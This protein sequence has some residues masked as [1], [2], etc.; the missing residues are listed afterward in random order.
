MYNTCHW[1]DKINH[2]ISHIYSQ[3]RG[4]GPYTPCRTTPRLHSGESEPAGAVKGRLCSNKRVSAPWLQ[5]ENMI[6]LFELFPRLVERLRTRGAQLVWLTGEQ[7]GWGDFLT[8]VEHTWCEQ[9]T[10]QL[11][12]WAL[13]GSEVKDVHE[14]RSLNNIVRPV[15]KHPSSCSTL[16]IPRLLRHPHLQ[17]HPSYCLCFCLLGSQ[18]H[19]C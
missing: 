6:G 16:S 17:F 5:W 3:P 10:S 13:E 2:F 4:Q 7:A 14:T 8:G 15:S 9:G 12:V 11:G 18:S 1:T 19:P